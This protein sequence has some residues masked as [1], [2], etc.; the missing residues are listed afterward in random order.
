MAAG[1]LTI[2]GKPAIKNEKLQPV[3]VRVAEPA[4]VQ[5]P[6]KET[7]PP[8]PPPRRKEPRPQTPTATPNQ[9]LKT[10]ASPTT[11]PIQGLTKDSL[12]PGGTMAAPIGNTL[13]T[14]DTG[15][16]EKE[17]Q[18]LQGDLSAPAR[19]I[20]NSMVTPPYTDEALDAMVEGSFIVDVYVNLDGS[21]RDVELRRKIGYGMDAR[22][23]TAVKGAKFIPRKNRLGVLEEG[24]TEL[25]FTLVIP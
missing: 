20:A 4:V 8:P 3:R 1:L 19:L 13:M 9:V 14:G 25:K 18:P 6:I 5:E 2:K 7:P 10:E 16:R 22:V 23:L 12:S 17:V 24:W 21:V 15:K 11:L